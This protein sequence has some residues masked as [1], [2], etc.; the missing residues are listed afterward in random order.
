[1]VMWAIPVEERNLL[2]PRREVSG[3]VGIRRGRFEWREQSF[4]RA[5]AAVDV[6]LMAFLAFVAAASP[7]CFL[8]FTLFAP[9]E[10]YGCVDL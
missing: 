6:P 8:P 2:R 1:M 7:V 9:S 4:R 10:V 5:L 3:F